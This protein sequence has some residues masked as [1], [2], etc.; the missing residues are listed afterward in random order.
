MACVLT[1]DIE[2]LAESWLV[3]TYGEDLNPM[4]YRPASRQR[5]H[6]QFVLQAV[7]PDYVR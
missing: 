1:G 4:Y 6:R 7:Q 2:A 3:E 5:L